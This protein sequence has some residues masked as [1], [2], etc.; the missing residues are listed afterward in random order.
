MRKFWGFYQN[1]SYSVGCNGST[2]YVYDKVGKEIAKFKDFPY[3]YKAT[4]MPGKNIIAV[5]S[6]EG[7]IGFYDLNSL[8]LIKKKKRLSLLELGHRMKDF[9]S[10]LMADFSIILKNQSPQ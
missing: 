5:K 9:H 10:H 6:T 1:E 2:V 4:F 8:S 3:A 7:Y